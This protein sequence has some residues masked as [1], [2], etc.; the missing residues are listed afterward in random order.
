VKATGGA[1]RP[2]CGRC[3]APL[4]DDAPSAVPAMDRTAENRRA[5]ALIVIVAVA[6]TGFAELLLIILR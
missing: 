1:L 2:V 4:G 3:G 5:M 6:L